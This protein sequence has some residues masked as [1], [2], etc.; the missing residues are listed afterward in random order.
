MNDPAIQLAP[1]PT[2][3]GPGDSGPPEDRELRILLEVFEGP[4]DLLLHLIRTQEIDIYDI[5]IAQVTEQYLQY[6]EL[7][8]NLNVNVAGEFLVM[9]A[10]LILIK[11][12]ML[13]PPDP[14][15]AQEEGFEDPR[16]ELVEQLLEYEKFKQAAHLLYERETVELC[17]W[18]RGH[19][20][21]E[22]EENEMVDVSVFDLVQAFHKIVE[23]YKDKVV[24]EVAHEQ[25]TIEEKLTEIRALV[26]LKGE[27]YF[28]LFL[29]NRISRT[30]LVLTLFALLEMVRLQEVSLHQKGVFE[31]IRIVAC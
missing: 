16:A 1:A 22:E 8:K 9:A 15:S 2:E 5:P 21:F 28:S 30:H 14:N 3:A 6:L 29:Q 4:L 27:F 10:T 12:K 20:E 25:V 24:M 23:R 7:M 11:S 18:P 17:I 31:D 19:E 13:L 26:S